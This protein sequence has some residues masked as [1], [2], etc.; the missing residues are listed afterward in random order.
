MDRLTIDIC[1]PETWITRHFWAWRKRRAFGVVVAFCPTVL[2]V[3]VELITDESK[4]F[5]VFVGPLWLGVAT[6]AIA[7]PDQHGERE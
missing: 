2:A 3:G 5:A 4:G 7:A 1:A 6:I